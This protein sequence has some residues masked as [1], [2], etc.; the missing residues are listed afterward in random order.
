LSRA[1]KQVPKEDVLLILGD[2]NAIVGRR[3]PSAMSSTVGLCGLGET[4]EAGE[5]LED[6][7]LEHKLA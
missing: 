1:A 2:F 6:F 4:N 3:Q 7:C 5:Q